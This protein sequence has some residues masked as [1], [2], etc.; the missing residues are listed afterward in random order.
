M[1]TKDIELARQERNKYFR[2]YNSKNATKRKE[3]N[4]KYWAKKAKQGSDK[5]QDGE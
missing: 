4:A 3:Y 5:P 1:E 2:E